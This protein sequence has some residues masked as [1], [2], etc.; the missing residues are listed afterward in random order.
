MEQRPGWIKDSVVGSGPIGHAANIIDK[1]GILANVKRHGY[2]PFGEELLA[3]TGNRPT[4]QAYP[5]VVR[6]KSSPKK[7]RTTKPHSTFSRQDTTRAGR[8]D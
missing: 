2:L 8:D 1:T 3:S 4:G 5:G 7:N 6:V